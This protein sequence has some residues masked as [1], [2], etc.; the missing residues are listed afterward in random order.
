[1]KE[2]DTIL[3]DLKNIIS[4]SN[5]TVDDNIIFE[6]GIKIYLSNLIQNSKEKNIQSMKN[7]DNNFDR[8]MEKPTEKQINFLKKN[9]Y[10]GI[11]P[12]T[13]NETRKLISKLME[14]NY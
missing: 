1:M 10:Q 12:N 6:Q 8:I 13:K 11:I 7:K 14:T 2:L 3:K 4:L 5:L 9:G